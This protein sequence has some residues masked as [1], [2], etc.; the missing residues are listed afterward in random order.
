MTRWTGQPAR[1]VEDERL[2]TGAGRYVDDI[3][4][5]GMLHLVAVRSPLAHARVVRVDPNRPGLANRADLVNRAARAVPRD[6]A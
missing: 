3:A 5:P 1:R 6:P 4:L 2:L